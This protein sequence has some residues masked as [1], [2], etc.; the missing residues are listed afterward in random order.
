MPALHTAPQGIACKNPRYSK[1]QLWQDSSV[2]QQVERARSNANYT[3]FAL[4]GNTR[5]AA[6]AATCVVCKS[7]TGDYNS[8]AQFAFVVNIAEK[9]LMCNKAT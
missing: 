9:H 4:T 8:V 2:K 1:H 7:S 3:L 6:L 5:Y